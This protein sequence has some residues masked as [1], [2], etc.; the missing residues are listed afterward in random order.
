M[1]DTYDTPW[2][3]ML[4]RYFKDFMAFFFPDAHADIDWR[5][6]WESCDI[7]L[8]K[9]VSRA[10]VGKRLA[11]KLTSVRTRSAGCQVMV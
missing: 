1:T 3:D 11:D 2:K 10:E 7:E 4:D 9:I 5:R 6:G 8:R